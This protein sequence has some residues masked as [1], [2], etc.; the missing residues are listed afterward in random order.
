MHNLMNLSKVAMSLDAI[1]KELNG[2]RTR[3]ENVLKGA[4]DVISLS[5]KSIV[6][7]HLEDKIVARKLLREAKRKLVRLRRE[8]R[9][10]LTKHLISPETEYVEAEVLFSIITKREIPGFSSLSVHEPS[11]I[12]GLL[13]AIGEI[14]RLILD[15]IRTGQSTEA[16]ELFTVAESLY[17]MISPFASFDKIADGTRRKLDV[18]R[19]L[20]ENSRAVV[21][22]DRRRQDLIAAMENLSVGLSSGRS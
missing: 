14:K 22:E 13:D 11:Y 3:R 4:R 6:A 21:T 1:S 17:V 20:V 18:A 7:M 10:D 5:S 16:S 9:H 2:V 19:A 12:L 8:A 15:R